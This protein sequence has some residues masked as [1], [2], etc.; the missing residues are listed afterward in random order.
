[1]FWEL[2]DEARRRAKGNSEDQLALLGK[3][4]GELPEDQIV[5]FGTAFDQ[6]HARGYTWDLWGA[7]YLI[8]GG[9]S[10]DGFADFRGWLI[11]QGQSVYDAALSNP[12]SLAP[13]AS[14]YECECQVE[15]FQY[16]AMQAWAKKT[17]GALRD[18]PRGNINY[19]ESSRRRELGRRRPLRSFSSFVQDRCRVWPL[20]GLTN[21]ALD[22]HP[23]F[24]P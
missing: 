12:E 23:P 10:D 6:H 13:L 5:A 18:F 21:E 19:E 14:Q 9:C 8:G 11:S 20:V 4:L 16:L 15:G 24:V 2:I 3:M 17:G 22:R 7:A 1:M